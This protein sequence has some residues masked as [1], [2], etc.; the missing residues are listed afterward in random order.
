MP[1]DDVYL[2]TIHSSA[3]LSR[4]RRRR[5]ALTAGA[6]LSLSA[7]I[8][9][10]VAVTAAVAPAPWK[11]WSSLLQAAPTRTV[12]A[13]S[14]FMG[15]SLV[16]A[17]AA[18]MTV[19]G[20]GMMAAHLP[21]AVGRFGVRALQMV[22]PRLLRNAL[23][24]ATGI[25]LIVGVSACST[26]AQVGTPP[27]PASP[28]VGWTA[29]GLDDGAADWG[30]G[31]AGYDGASDPAE[32]ATSSARDMPDDSSAQTSGTA[33]TVDVDWLTTPIPAQQSPVKD[34]PSTGP[35]VTLAPEATRPPVT[36]IPSQGSPADISAHSST[37]PR[38]GG[39]TNADSGAAS[40][41]REDRATDLAAEPAN[42]A[43]DITAID[44]A[45]SQPLPGDERSSD[46]VTVRPGDTLWSIAAANLGPSATTAEIDTEWRA[47][48]A[49]NRAT[50]GMNPDLI[51][52]GQTLAVPTA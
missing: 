52:P 24:A 3:A 47:W 9:G 19:V 27:E 41:E 33:V 30:A 45:N 20:L 14:T 38:P 25:T 13:I 46:A 12:D 11:L 36:A 31:V 32:S 2:L 39:D 10:G 29:D 16:W 15:A 44:S 49:A 6:R 23:T 21:G 35:V 51:F 48:Y 8:V 50:I 17:I 28:G 37:D 4:I 22:T 7:V 26:S 18:W 5:V 43:A 1:F 40:T 34:P 42:S